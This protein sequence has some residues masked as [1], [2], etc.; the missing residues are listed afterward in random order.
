MTALPERRV[1]APRFSLTIQPVWHIA[2]Q[3]RE[4]LA[5]VLASHCPELRYSAT[6]TASE[7]VENAIKYGESVPAARDIRFSLWEADG[8]LY[9]QTVNG[10]TDDA[11]IR[12]LTRRVR[13]IATAPD[14][15]AL[16]V[17]RVQELLERPSECGKLGMYRIATEGRFT[18]QC[19]Y[20]QS[21]VTVTATRN[22]S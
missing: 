13:E 17:A 6:M 21:V 1:S 9:I 8:V 15:A 18:L 12:D 2:R 19:E 4:Q 10:C 3:L 20:Q 16:Y 5:E 7:L 22:I 11:G 14:P